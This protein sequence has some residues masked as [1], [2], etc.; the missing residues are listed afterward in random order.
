MTLQ[1]NRR[2]VTPVL[3]WLLLIAAAAGVGVFALNLVRREG[4]RLESEAR[5]TAQDR[6]RVLADDLV[7]AVREVQ[8]G[9]EAQLVRL[10]PAG[11]VQALPGWVDDNPL[12]RN[13]FVWREA[14][15]QLLL[16][17]PTSPR[18][19][20]ERRFIQRYESLFSGRRAWTDA[21]A[22]P[23]S[24]AAAAS[25]QSFQMARGQLIELANTSQ[26]QQAG[27]LGTQRAVE[28]G[29]ITWFAEDQLFLLG[30]TRAGGRVWGVELETAALL[31]GLV[32][33]FPAER[34]EG[35][36]WAMLDGE[37]R[38]VHQVGA[39]E[40]RGTDAPLAAASL[41]PVLPHWQIALFRTA[42]DL[43]PAAARN[44]R[45]YALLLVAVLLVSIIAGG[46]LLMAEARRSAR[47]ARQ[48]TTFVSNVSHELKTPLTT[49]RLYAEMLAEGRVPDEARRRHYLDV[50]VAETA[51]LTRLVNNMLDF[52]RIE[53][54][55]R[56]YALEN[57]DLAA[58]LPEFADA[59]RP[60][61]AEAG[62][63]LETTIAGEPVVARADR[64][65]VEQ[66]VLNL[67]DN[68]AKYAAA[69]GEVRV[70]LGSRDGKATLDVLDRGPGVPV[71]L[72]EKVFE[73]F[74]RTDDSLTTRVPGSGLGLSI[75]RRLARDMG[76]DL[77]C[78]PRE[79]QGGCFRLT[80]ALAAGD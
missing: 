50:M 30:W 40:V 74:Y 16:P 29:W 44:Y 75:A 77:V 38:V 66:A 36:T 45:L 60:R 24:V 13:V 1:M 39:I 80:L 25:K 35:R 22:R 51:R 14:G 42:R 72:R 63:K 11:A 41:G 20:E 10:D 68:A 49:L 46:G 3:G 27:P 43:T 56:T 73:K 34:T 32:A 4:A 5:L 12:V 6:A 78:L 8:Q 17:D 69:G 67:L 70:A 9:L 21:A 64:D 7:L 37:D 65:A 18:T 15:A 55:R 79:G 52:S 33:A 2:L 47:E 61:L 76:G 57:L 48:K 26:V 19:G 53:Q 71:Q 23:E 31:A 28:S 54:G 58:W 62:L 59:H